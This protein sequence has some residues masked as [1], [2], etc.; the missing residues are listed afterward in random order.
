METMKRAVLYARVSRDDRSNDG[1]NLA[2]QLE[3]GREYA[4][5]HGYQVMAE[6]AEDDRGASGAEIDLPELNRVRN[7]ALA[8]EFDVLVVREIDRLSR[9]LAK[10]LI[11]EQELQRTGVQIEYAIGEYPDTPE[12]RLNKHIKATIAEYEREKIAERTTRARRQKVKGGHVITRSRPPYGYRSAEVNGRAMLTIYEPEARIVSMIFDWYTV[13]DGEDGPLST[14]AIAK[15]LSDMGIPTWNDVHKKAG[16]KRRR[17]EWAVSVIARVLSNETYIGRWHYAGIPVD[18]PAIVDGETWSA[19]QKRKRHDL[20]MSKRN[21]KY[22][23]LL[24]GRVRCGSCG[25]SVCGT[26]KATPKGVPLLPLHHT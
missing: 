1:R 15:R 3:M 20:R 7:M 22:D 13:G 10:Q 2:G 26:S 12:G 6:L 21:R 25:M 24:G 11:V 9:N 4:Q 16:K 17:G 5:E 23:Y 14:R 19:V 18:V 8:G